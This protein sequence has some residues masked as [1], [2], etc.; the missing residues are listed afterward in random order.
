[1]CIIRT[2]NYF[3]VLLLF[4]LIFLALTYLLIYFSILHGVLE[5]IL[6]F[7]CLLGVFAAETALGL[8]LFSHRLSSKLIFKLKKEK[9]KKK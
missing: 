5:G 9:S 1:M 4:E 6:F 8:S 7:L 3:K 2:F